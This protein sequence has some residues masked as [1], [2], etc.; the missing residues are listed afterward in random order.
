MGADRAAASFS[1]NGGQKQPANSGEQP[2]ASLLLGCR[3]CRDCRKWRFSV[4]FGRAL[5]VFPVQITAITASSV[6]DATG[7]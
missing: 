5:T 7:S 3:G 6:L 4:V 1:Q 2:A